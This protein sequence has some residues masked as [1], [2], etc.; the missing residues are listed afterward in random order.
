MEE[1]KG[2][3]SWAGLLVELGRKEDLVGPDEQLVL[4]F[5]SQSFGVQINTKQIQ[6]EIQI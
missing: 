1:E 6:N 3:G 4:M 5:I 2:N